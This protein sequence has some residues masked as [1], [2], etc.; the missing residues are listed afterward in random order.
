[1]YIIF[2]LNKVY[3]FVVVQRGEKLAYIA[4]A[5]YEGEGVCVTMEASDMNEGEMKEANFNIQKHLLEQYSTYFPVEYERWK[6][7]EHIYN[8]KFE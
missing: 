5:R 8:K 1:M 4:G 2:G 3:I 6:E 7:L